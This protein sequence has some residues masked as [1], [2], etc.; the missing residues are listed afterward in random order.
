MA[1]ALR[2]VGLTR[3]PR[4]RLPRNRHH[5]PTFTG[6]LKTLWGIRGHTPKR[7]AAA[8]LVE[9]GLILAD[10][11]FEVDQGEIVCVAGQDLRGAEILFSI[12]A[13]SLPPTRGRIEA[14]GVIASA[15]SAGDRLEADATAVENIIREREFLSVPD[16][17]SK[18]EHVRRIIAFAGLEGFEHVPVRRFSTGMQ[19]RLAVGILVFSE[20]PIILI[21]DIMGVADVEFQRRFIGR[22][23]ELSSAGVATLLCGPVMLR[24]DF[25]TRVIKLEGGKIASD[26][27]PVA[28]VKEVK[29][30]ASHAWNVTRPAGKGRGVELIDI[31]ITE[32]TS[33]AVDVA[34]LFAFDTPQRASPAIEIKYGKRTI[35][36]SGPPPI[37]VIEPGRMSVVVGV[38]NSF[39]GGRDYVVDVTCLSEVAGDVREFI[40]RGAIAIKPRVS[41]SGGDRGTPHLR[42]ALEWLV[43]DFVDSSS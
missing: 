5:N 29:P 41:E 31:A 30:K 20:A 9:K 35:L 25:V 11:S 43:E 12:I 42:A 26:A 38:P 2:V 8:A 33:G 4:L 36:Q 21:G 17:I 19:L 40:H 37:D 22:I 16:T 24:R 3:G 13:G 18:D 39:L 10:L 7:A 1:V 6:V 27:A 23:K 34:L 28:S 14:S 32:R 15:V